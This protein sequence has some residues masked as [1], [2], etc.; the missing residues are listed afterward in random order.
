VSAAR[1]GRILRVVVVGYILALVASHV[2]R[3][4]DPFRPDPAPWL[5]TVTLAEVRKDAGLPRPVQVAFFDSL[6]STVDSPPTVVLLHGSPGSHREVLAIARGLAGAYRVIAPDLP[7]FGASTRRI[8]DYSVDA[9]A[10]YLGRL[11]DSLG[12]RRAHLV[13][14]SMGGGVALALADREPSRVASITGRLRQRQIFPHSGRG[15]SS[16]SPGSNNHQRAKQRRL[17][18]TYY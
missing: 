5:R 2:A 13:G 9:H 6:P 1:S 17:A 12:L 3:R 8:A 16:R 7:G 4:V 11:L 10:R 14:F 18:H 15:Y